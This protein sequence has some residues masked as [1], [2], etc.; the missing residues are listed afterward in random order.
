MTFEEEEGDQEDEEDEDENVED[1]DDE[2]AGGPS[3]EDDNES[4]SEDDDAVPL[5]IS[6]NKRAR[7]ASD[8]GEGSDFT[9][10][11]RIITG[12]ADMLVNSPSDIDA[13]NAVKAAAGALDH[14]T[15]SR[16]NAWQ[17]FEL[18]KDLPAQWK[19]VQTE[20]K[21]RMKGFEA[22]SK[23]ERKKAQNTAAKAWGL[24]D[25]LKAV[26]EKAATAVAK[27]AVQ[28]ELIRRAILIPCVNL[29]E[30]DELQGIAN[31]MTSNTVKSLAQQ[32][33]L[34]W[35][36]C[37]L[38]SDKVEMVVDGVFIVKDFMQN[39][40]ATDPADVFNELRSF[41][42]HAVDHD[43]KLQL[44]KPHLIPGSHPSLNYRGNELQR[45]KIWM[46][47]GTEN[48]HLKYGYT[49]WQNPIAMAMVDIDNIPI[50]KKV[51]ADIN[52]GLGVNG[53]AAH[54]H[55]IYTQYEC[56]Q[57]NIGAHHDKMR[58][59]DIS[60]WIIVVKLGEARPF[61]FYQSQESEIPLWQKTLEAGTAVF[62]NARGNALVR[63][64]VPKCD[65]VGASGSIV[66]RCITTL[67]PWDTMETG[68]KKVIENRSKKK[69]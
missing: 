69:K 41:P 61:A 30:T 18:T 4:S 66:T 58:D 26:R 42:E 46:Q 49:G 10:P 22:L 20:A 43:I 53:K 65:K 14:L 63:H 21:K 62:M 16:Y 56:D 33:S 60:S 23:E 29:A 68:A 54:N 7:E 3:G 13:I 37:Q 17:M 40:L 44:D 38:R 55:V 1:K 50:A 45:K 12:A 57:D 8:A 36:G 15:E 67:V 47:S 51:L 28:D 25:L 27:R 31:H 24:P 2:E 32:S 19:N 35:D 52:T 48:G 11:I 34:V 9:N 59:I 6:P 39:Q 64:G 5:P